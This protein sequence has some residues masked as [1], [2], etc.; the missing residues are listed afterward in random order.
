MKRSLTAL[1]ALLVATLPSIA[2]AAPLAERGSIT[3]TIAV[4]TSV[5][6]ML[7]TIFPESSQVGASY[8]SPVFD[9][10]IVISEPA[11]VSLTF[12]WEGAGYLNSFGYFTYSL[13]A[14]GVTILDRQLVF[15]NASFSDPAK[16]WG[17]GQLAT[18]DTAVLAD[19]NGQPRVFQPGDRIGFFVVSNGW[20]SSS[21]W[22]N[23]AAPQYPSTDPATNAGIA[24]GVFTSIDALNPEMSVSRSDVARH[25]AMVLFTGV[26]GFLNGAD[27]I[28]IGMED[29]RRDKGADND[30]NDVL[31]LVQSTPETA[32]LNTNVPS[33]DPTNSDP[34]GDGVKGLADFF[35]DDPSRAFV[36]RT[37]TTSYDTIAF[38]D[39]YPS[40]GDAD[41]NDAVIQFAYENVTAANGSVKEIIGTFHLIARGAGLD[42]SFGVT[43]EGLPAGASGTIT[44]E[45]F[46]SD[47]TERGSQ[48]TPIAGLLSSSTGGLQRITIQD[49]FPSTRAALLSPDGYTNTVSS[50]P[51][52]PPASA[53]FRIVFDTTISA[54]TLSAAPHDPFLGVKHGADI[55]DIHMPGKHGLA[56]RP[57]SLPDESGS[58]TFVDANAH[59][60]AL[61]VPFDWRYPLEK[62]PIDGSVA[63]YPSF[64]T[65]TSSAG[66]TSKDWFKTPAIAA[67]KRVV[68]PLTNGV[69]D[70]PWTVLP[71]G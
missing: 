40:V 24:N 38:E 47:G 1:A 60:W 69:R 36:V 16:G 49:I 28:T 20:S 70:R 32:I 14:N 71:G 11:K 15:P 31:F 27:F 7:G 68:D 13:D 35:P 2:H 56:G 46:D 54:T 61:L 6:T 39:L 9:P 41:Y 45:T 21:T 48:P 10:N 19:A 67:K 51:S 5:M 17:G 37:P 33:V 30:F 50:V 66:T 12:L 64:E 58:V 55:W 8:V 23:P 42:H 62:Q 63:A 53:R 57:A 25:A 44:F 4:P 26:P 3:S 18:G 59:P 43:I 29:L 34:D 52:T 22:W 65:W